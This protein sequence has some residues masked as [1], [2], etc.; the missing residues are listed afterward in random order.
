MK[1]IKKEGKSYLE[2]KSDYDGVIECPFCFEKHKHGK[3]SGHR[4]AHCNSKVLP[5]FFD[6]EWHKKEDGY[7][8]N[9]L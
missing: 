5:V 7:F 6:G 2:I 9:Y 3:E 1:A 8:I 4:I